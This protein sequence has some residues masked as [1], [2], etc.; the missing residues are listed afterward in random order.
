MKNTLLE[1]AREAREDIREELVRTQTGTPAYNRLF[2]TATT[3][4][5]LIAD[6]ER[7]EVVA[8]D[9]ADWTETPYLRVPLTPAL[10]V[11]NA[12][13]AMALDIVD[14]LDK[15]GLSYVNRTVVA[16]AI[17]EHEA[18]VLAESEKGGPDDG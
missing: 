2:N 16:R 9:N 6:L 12:H 7:G 5:S 3:L 14:A 18:R 11:T 13:E 15:D 17:A 10:V 8:H 4:D 1:R